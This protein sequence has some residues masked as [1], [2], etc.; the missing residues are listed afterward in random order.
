MTPPFPAT[1]VKVLVAAGAA[2]DKGQGLVVVSAMKTE[3][4]L[5]APHAGAVRAI[6]CKEGQSV[7]PGDVLVELDEA[8]GESDE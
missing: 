6:N 1:V 3:M 5:K 8:E 4:T 2:V 7:S